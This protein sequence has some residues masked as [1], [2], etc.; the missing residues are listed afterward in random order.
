VWA[1]SLASFTND[2]ASE[3]LLTL[4]PIY[5]HHNLKSPVVVIGVIEGIALA[6]TALIKVFAGW[7]SDRIKSRKNLTAIGYALS[8]FA[9]PVLALAT[10]WPIVATVRWLDRIG[11]GFR[12]APRDALIAD[13]IEK[14]QRGV[15]FGLHR[16]SETAGA[17]IS[18]G[19]ALYIV[20]TQQ[21]VETD[22]DRRSYQILVYL[23]IPFG[24]GA[25]ASIIFIAKER[26]R[27]TARQEREKEDRVHTTNE[28]QTSD[29]EPTEQDPLLQQRQLQSPVDI[30]DYG[31]L[32][33]IQ[34]EPSSA[35][36]EIQPLPP[37]MPPAR[38]PL[39]VS[40]W[41]TH[42][43]HDHVPLSTIAS[44]SELVSPT[45]S[46]PHSGL[47]VATTMD[48][49]GSVERVGEYASLVT[50]RPLAD[51]GYSHPPLPAVSRS[52]SPCP[53]PERSNSQP[54]NEFA[55]SQQ[56][57]RDL[58]DRSNSVSTTSAASVHF[59]QDPKR[60][61]EL[62]RLYEKYKD[63]ITKRG[64]GIL[65]GKGMRLRQRVR[66][67]TR[68]NLLGSSHAHGL[69]HNIYHQSYHQF[70]ESHQHEHEHEPEHEDER[71]PYYREGGYCNHVLNR[72]GSVYFTLL[73]IFFVFQI[74]NPPE[75]FLILYARQRG[76]TVSEL[77]ALMLVYNLTYAAVSAPAGWISDRVEK[78]RKYSRPYVIVAG[79]VLRCFTMTALSVATNTTQ[80]WVLFCLH[81]AYMGIVEGTVKAVIVDVVDRDA[82]VRGLAFGAFNG[83]MGFADLISCTLAGL[84]WQ[85]SGASTPF[86]FAAIS[87]GIA[88]LLL[89]I[90]RQNV[91]P[92]EVT[93]E[94]HDHKTTALGECPICY[95]V[96][97]E[98]VEAE[99]AAATRISPSSVNAM[100]PW[101]PGT[102]AP[103][104]G[105]PVSSP[106]S[107]N[108]RA[109][110]TNEADRQAVLELA[111]RDAMLQAE[112][113]LWKA[114]RNRT[115]RRG[116]QWVNRWASEADSTQ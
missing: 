93:V 14:W 9:R 39:I 49:E 47:S 57:Q 55:P 87:G 12:G 74:G 115:R 92:A 34:V 20:T 106:L 64:F 65:A 27:S 70:G 104:D 26:F 67:H 15:S 51:V 94:A 25:V 69:S 63:R 86:R 90:W 48:S 105:G 101:L 58:E 13:S 29:G 62:K 81:G 82:T 41:K 23:S 97:K 19:I 54:V 84:L 80:I 18:L 76:V 113:A 45:D 10:S 53:V 61:E 100:G 91:Q 88:A 33:H 109:A 42:R 78:A 108:E 114:R 4:M 31:A 17:V 72:L 79:W 52:A 21:P 37:D 56:M 50:T 40:S 35:T 1:L 24:V 22:L 73:S 89:L 16:A 110:L 2:I 44:P 30:R 46:G 95:A 68:M 83:I 28:T 59:S 5:L 8:T 3:M 38:P 112:H 43:H 7:L 102:F 75:A 11:K 107:D 116:W 36:N 98:A 32:Q 60:Q 6:V 99:L 77:L 85:Q 66:S 103:D 111:Y 71:D 96:A